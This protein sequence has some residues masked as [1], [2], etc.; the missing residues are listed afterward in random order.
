[1]PPKWPSPYK[2]AKHASRKVDISDG[3]V[4][5]KEFVESFIASDML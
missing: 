3:K 2:K 5:M 4:S 1:M